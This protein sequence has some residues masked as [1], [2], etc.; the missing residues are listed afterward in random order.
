[1]VVTWATKLTALSLVGQALAFGLGIFLARHLSV[2]DFE[3]YVVASAAFV[4]MVTLVPQGI[5]KYT[6]MVIPPLLDR[7]R[8]GD[9]RAYLR[10][11]CLRILIACVLAG[12][13][14]T[15]LALHA[16]ELR[17]ETRIALVISCA[18]LPAGALVHFA[19]EV[20]TAF[21]R[22]F[23]A[24]A[25]F[26]VLVPTVVLA[27]TGLAFA[28]MP[29]A[30]GA[31]AIAAWGAA[32]LIALGLM[33][34]RIRDAVPKDYWL[35]PASRGSREWARHA[36]PFWFYRV[37]MAVLAQAG[38]V[39]LDRLQPSASE[40]GAFAV[41]L[42]TASI[43]QVLATA[44]NRVYA[45]RLSRLL[46]GGDLQAVKALRQARLRWITAPLAIWLIVV[47]LFAGE[48]LSLFRPEF[49]EAG[50]TPL[51]LLTLCI[52]LT[53]LLS[54]EPMYFKH[55]RHNRTLFGNV[56]AAIVLQ[57]ML[58]AILAPTQGATGAAVAYGIAMT[59]LYLNLARVARLDLQ[60]AQVPQ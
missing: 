58:L 36:R 3:S 14:V 54:V 44:T 38:V 41:A 51:R 46:E 29:Q 7:H 10:F 1:M 28:W 9:V 52:A 59:L 60:N 5:E 43:A 16:G 22:P 53:T 11:G 13:P 49:V 6:L 8:A 4:L 25:I 20:L 56:V 35:V 48:I 34:W 26:R 15:L 12:V 55:R 21:G 24:T 32:W 47:L 19:I 40:V 45:S 33:A 39:A 50:K 23:A 27:V 31:M 18:S 2:E 37:S 17:Q 57:V 42:S 30:G